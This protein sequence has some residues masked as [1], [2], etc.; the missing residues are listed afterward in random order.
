MNQQRS[1]NTSLASFASAQR[2]RDSGSI[3][4]H[5]SVVTPPFKS[6]D[7]ANRHTFNL[8]WPYP[9]TPLETSAYFKRTQSAPQANSPA[10]PIPTTSFEEF[11]KSAETMLQSYHRTAMAIESAQTC[12]PAPIPSTAAIQMPL[13]LTSRSAPLASHRS[14]APTTQRSAAAYSARSVPTTHLLE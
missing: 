10:I 11:Q 5:D 8:Q 13:L 6:F 2:P 7:E 12:G 14:G 4:M 9:F 3:S 1:R